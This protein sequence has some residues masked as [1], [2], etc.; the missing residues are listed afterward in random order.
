MS[1]IGL[2]HPAVRLRPRPGDPEDINMKIIAIEE[3]WNSA[4]IRDALD[5][6]PDGMRDESVAFNAMGDNQARLEDIGLGRSS[7]SSTPSRT[8]RTVPRSPPATRKP[9]SN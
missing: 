7:S 8:P 9:Y 4:G 2:I 6:L 5:R 3:H 1:E